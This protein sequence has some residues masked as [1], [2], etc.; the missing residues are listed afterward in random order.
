[1]WGLFREE[2]GMEILLMDGVWHKEITSTISFS[3]SSSD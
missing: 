3:I 1:M 2:L